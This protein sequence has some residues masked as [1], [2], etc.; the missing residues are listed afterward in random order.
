[1]RG[2]ADPGAADQVREVAAAYGSPKDITD[3]QYLIREGLS[4][5]A[6]EGLSEHLGSS[7]AELAELLLI[8]RKTIQRR[9]KEDRLTPEES[10][11]LIRVARILAQA[12]VVFG[13][14]ERARGWLRSPLTALG[15]SRPWMFLDTDP[16]VR[17]LEK[18]LGRIEYGVYG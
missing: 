11:R 14:E 7:Q 8:S 6:F 9:K 5:G 12:V 10:D 17:R 15:G 13:D 16:G 1:M 2:A 18:I 3:L 4:Y